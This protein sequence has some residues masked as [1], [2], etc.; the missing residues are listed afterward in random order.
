MRRAEEAE[1]DDP[2]EPLDWRRILP[3][4]PVAASD[5]LA[6]VG[7]QAARYRAAPAGEV[8]SPA[9]THHRLVFVT[10]PPEEAELR[11]EGVTR[12]VL[13]PTGSISLVPAGSPAWVRV[14]ECK[15]QLHIFLE[16]ELV[17]RAAAEAFDLDP[18]RVSIPP[19]DGL[20][21]PPLRTAMGAAG[22]R[23]PGHRPGR[24][25]AP[26]GPGAPPIGARAGWRA[27]A[28][29]APRRRRLH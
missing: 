10:R 13:P 1:R 20:D 26:T 29:E 24:P 18:A 2:I 15:D 19:L 17:A 7:L 14:S 8:N 16:P 9:L 12:H 3:F 25:A 22:R 23:G 21:L 5:R 27:A 6:W 11:Y 28:G 4:V